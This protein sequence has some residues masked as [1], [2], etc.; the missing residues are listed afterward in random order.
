[1]SKNVST[2]SYHNFGIL[3]KSRIYLT[4]LFI[5]ENKSLLPDRGSL[6]A[7]S[8]SNNRLP[9]LRGVLDVRLKCAGDGLARCKIGVNGPIIGLVL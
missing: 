2:C 8:R 5:F 4:D 1:M 7:S 9:S 6:G 3:E